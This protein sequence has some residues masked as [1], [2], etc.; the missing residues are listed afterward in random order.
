M[1]GPL[2]EFEIDRD[3]GDYVPQL[4]TNTLYVVDC[5]NSRIRYIYL[6]K[7]CESG[8]RFILTYVLTL[9]ACLLTNF[10]C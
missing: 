7:S 3:N 5:P 1:N 6:R 2:R 9:L 8:L 10:A 4:V